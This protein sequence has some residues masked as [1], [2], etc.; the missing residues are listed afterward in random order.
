MSRFFRKIIAAAYK[1]VIN[2]YPLNHDAADI[3]IKH[4]F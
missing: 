4:D 2:A 3:L 1:S